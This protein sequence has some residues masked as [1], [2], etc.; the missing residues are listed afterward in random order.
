MGIHL[1]PHFKCFLLIIYSLFSISA[2]GY[3]RPDGKWAS[4]NASELF[5]ANV[6]LSN[7]VIDPNY[8]AVCEEARDEIKTELVN[9]LP[10]KISPLTLNTTQ[11][12]DAKSNRAASLILRITQCEIDVDQSG[13]SFTYYLTLA[14]DVRV[15]KNGEDLLSY[16]M[17]THEQV[18]IDVPNPDFEFTFAE[19]ISRTLQLFN[20]K[21]VWVPSKM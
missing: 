9:K 13:G 15:T 1:S 5:F 16:K 2:C 19:P 7:E 21:Q 12:P 4:I 3:Q 6:E 14:L 10:E 20:G 18:H 11:K 8:K 17:N